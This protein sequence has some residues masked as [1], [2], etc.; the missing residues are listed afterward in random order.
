MERSSPTV[1]LNQENHSNWREVIREYFLESFDNYEQLFTALNAEEAWVLRSEPLRHPLIFYYGHTAAFYINKFVTAGIIDPRNRVDPHIE[2]LVAVGVDEMSWDTLLPDSFHWPKSSIVREYRS[3]V[4]Q[5]TLNLINTLE[6]PSTLNPKSPWWIILMGIEHERIHLET[7][8]VILRR[9]PIQFVDE[10]TIERF[11][12]LNPNSTYWLDGMQKIAPSFQINSEFDYSNT[13]DL[14]QD[15]LGKGLT[16][17][18]TRNITMGR[19]SWSTASADG[20]YGWDNEFGTDTFTVPTFAARN[21]LVTNYEFYQFWK[22]GGYSEKRFWTKQGWKWA[23][24]TK[25]K[26]PL[27]WSDDASSFRTLFKEIPMPW[28]YPVETNNYEAQAFA[29]WV[30]EKSL[31]STGNPNYSWRLPSEHEYTAFRLQILPNSILRDQN[32][33]TG[34]RYGTPTSVSETDELSD[35]VGNVWQWGSTCIYPF[36]GFET[37]PAYND[38][39]VPTYDG[40]HSMILGGSFISCGNMETLYARYAFRKHFYQFAGLRLIYAPKISSKVEKMVSGRL[41]Y[42]AETNTALSTEFHYGPESPLAP[43]NARKNFP[44][45]AVATVVETYRSFS[46][47]E[48]MKIADIG[49]GAG[50]AS[51]ELA[52]TFQ[53]SSVLGID[54][55][56]TYIRVAHRL[57]QS[58]SLTYTIPLQGA[59]PQYRTVSA[60]DLNITSDVNSRVK[61]IQADAHNLPDSIDYKFDLVFASN[62]ITHLYDPPLFFNNLFSRMNDDALLVLISPYNW[63]EEITPK[64]KWIGGRQIDAEFVSTERAL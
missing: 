28:S 5:L 36:Y 13:V 15:N 2:S 44:V 23:T 4:K 11:L 7:S 6:I 40:R 10:P 53:N 51:F 26:R 35:V 14:S 31:N 56:T 17:V 29:N 47:K 58:G 25:F 22:A 41:L 45:R 57:Q 63:S 61:F 1:V 46:Q 39:T 30:T 42:E 55:V 54:F 21:N 9:M 52:K 50:R 43:D 19:G 3:K 27:F 8:A 49:C 18:N 59:I 12:Q 62:L 24:T 32:A 16:K 60:A 20:I 64:E 38:F 34:L 33:N 48:P 37:H